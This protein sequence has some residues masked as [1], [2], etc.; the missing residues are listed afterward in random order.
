V[1]S[2]G[3]N[4]IKYGDVQVS[5][6]DNTITIYMNTTKVNGSLK[7]EFQI[8]KNVIDYP[9][10]LLVVK[11]DEKEIQCTQSE[12]S[13]QRILDCPIQAGSKELKIIGTIVIPEFGPESTVIFTASMLTLVLIFSRYGM[14]RLFST[15][16]VH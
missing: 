9:G 1:R 10:G 3:T 8:P 16:S 2:N 5:T 7:Q 4:Q 15:H 11:V 6:V 13:T 14:G 12:T